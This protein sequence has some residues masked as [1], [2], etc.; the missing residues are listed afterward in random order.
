M[1]KNWLP[2]VF[3]PGVGH[4]E[5]AGLGVLQIGMKLVG[6]LVAGPAAPGAFGT[7][8]LDHEVGNDA[9]KNEAVVKRLAG[10]GSLGQADEILHGLRRPVGEQAA[11]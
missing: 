8:A 6:E 11:L 2:L 9:M 5:H 7:S 1:T 4:G 10:L 3:G